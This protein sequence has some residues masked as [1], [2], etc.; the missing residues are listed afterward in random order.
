MLNDA[1]NITLIHFIITELKEKKYHLQV[2]IATPKKI[3][4]D[5]KITSS[6]NLEVL[7]T[8]KVRYDSNIYKFP[9]NQFSNSCIYFIFCNSV[10][11]FGKYALK[12]EF[13]SGK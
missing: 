3:L 11:S 2:V 4:N 7:K 8:P 12:N 6:I 5:W 9:L 10:W 13:T 1:S